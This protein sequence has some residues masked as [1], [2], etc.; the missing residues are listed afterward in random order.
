MRALAF[1]VLLILPALVY[2]ATGVVRWTVLPEDRLLEFEVVQNNAPVTGAFTDF[3]SDIHF[4]ANNLEESHIT[5][6][7]NTQAIETTY[8]EVA[9]YVR[10]PLW[11]DSSGHPEATF[12]SKSI[13]RDGDVYAATGDLTLKGITKP[14]TLSFTLEETS[15]GTR[16]TGQTVIKRTDYDVGSG[17]WADTSLVKDEVTIRFNF[18]AAKEA[19]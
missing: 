12:M 5:I 9:N 15:E 17:E 19:P 16:A 18:L 13:T 14:A 11:L 8:S 1:F 10:E 2:S 6:R 7:I 4:D 3:D